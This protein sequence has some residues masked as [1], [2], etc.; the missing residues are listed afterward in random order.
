MNT[1]DLTNLSKKFSYFS[2]FNFFTNQAE[3]DVLNSLPRKAPS[4]RQRA[5]GKKYQYNFSCGS[6][7]TLKELY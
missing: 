3:N 1:G 4:R 7:P 5:E 6:L 2:D